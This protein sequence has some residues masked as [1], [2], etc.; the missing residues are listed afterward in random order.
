MKCPPLAI[1]A[2]SKTVHD[3]LNGQKHALAFIFSTVASGAFFLNFVPKSR[4]DGLKKGPVLSRVPTTAFGAS[5][6]PGSS[7]LKA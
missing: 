2:R 1:S 4:P 6:T 7:R 3:L 5:P